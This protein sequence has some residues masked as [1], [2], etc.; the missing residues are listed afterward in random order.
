[1]GIIEILLLPFV[2]IM[3]LLSTLFGAFIALLVL[4]TTLWAFFDAR[5]RGRSG[6]LVS[7]LVF[8]LLWPLGL[9]LWIV[10]RPPRAYR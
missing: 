2:F 7:L 3:W 9:I 4:L 6:C 5:E 8:F 10:L 1:M